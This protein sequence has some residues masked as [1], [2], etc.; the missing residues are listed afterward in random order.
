MMINTEFGKRL[1]Y[2]MNKNKITNQ[3]LTE[4][5]NISKN[6]IGNYK[7]GQIP[8]ATILYTLSK[9]LGTSMEYLLAGKEPEDL[10]PEEKILVDKYRACSSVGKD[11][12]QQNADDMTKLY[13]ALPEGV[14]ACNSG[15]T[16]TNN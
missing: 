2:L 8:N 10:S 5:A 7:N 1:T 15:K 9:I 16:G 14:S 13:P 11:R 4:I 6:N 3:K 12:I